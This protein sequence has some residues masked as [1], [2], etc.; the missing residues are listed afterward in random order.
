MSGTEAEAPDR[1]GVA[2]AL[3]AGAWLGPVLAMLAGLALLALLGVEGEFI[4]LLFVVA[5]SLLAGAPAA[6]LAARR[7]VLGRPL[8]LATGGAGLAAFAL[9]HLLDGLPVAEALAGALASAALA[10]LWVGLGVAAGF[11]LPPLAGLAAGAL[12]G[13][14]LAWLVG[15]LAGAFW[16][17]ALGAA[18]AGFL[19]AAPA[20]AAPPRLRPG[21]ARVLA[22]Q[23]AAGLALALAVLAGPLMAYGTDGKLMA[24]ALALPVALPG[25]LLLAATRGLAP[26]PLATALLGLQALAVAL[27]LVIGGAPA[28]A[29]WV[30]V[31]GLPAFRLALLGAGF[32]PAFAA[33]AAALLERRSPRSA[34]LAALVLAVLSAGLGPLLGLLQPELADFGALA[35]PVLATGFAFWLLLRGEA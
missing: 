22:G 15:G 26:L 14:A 33:L 12:L 19:A 21:E 7:G 11:G 18:L 30:S 8:G 13:A 17:L 6:M 2:G 5:L 24:V 28:A 23:G 25:L 35:A 10:L 31:E 29:G 34:V 4:S 1:P 3:V 20:A 32:L 16:G 9:F 27:G